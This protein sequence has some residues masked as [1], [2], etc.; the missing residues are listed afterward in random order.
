VMH[1]A[2]TRDPSPSNNRLEQ[3]ILDSLFDEPTDRLV[4]MS[5]LFNLPIPDG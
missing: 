3:N 4:I 2:P 1:S 5:M